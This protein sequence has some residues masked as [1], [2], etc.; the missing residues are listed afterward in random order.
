MNFSMNDDQRRLVEQ[1]L[2]V[3][4]KVIWKSIRFDNQ[5]YGLEYDDLYQVGA[6]GLCK[7]AVAYE[8]WDNATFETYAYRVVRNEMLDHIRN[9]M[10]K[11][12]AHSK[13]ISDAE[14]LLAYQKHL[15][16]EHEIR[17][18]FAIQALID[19]KTRYSNTTQTGI[20]ALTL[21]LQGYNGS[22]IAEKYS[23]KP[24][25]VSACISRA[26]KYLREDKDFL[27]AIK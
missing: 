8:K 4:E 7:A 22:D 19:S 17:D 26:V 27:S 21:R 2:A 3:I 1:N 14:Q 20:D 18:K 10:K 6:I 12:A 24:N 11:K 9:V 5:N 25:Y 23:V 15:N 16:I 13:F